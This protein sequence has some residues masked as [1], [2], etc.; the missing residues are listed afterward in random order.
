[1]PSPERT[2][3]LVL[4][5]WGIGECRSSSFV[6]LNYVALGDLSMA[7]SPGSRGLLTAL[8]VARRRTRSPAA[9][10]SKRLRIT[11]TRTP[12]RERLVDP[13]AEE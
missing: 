7:M 10:L 13:G 1:M 2:R 9:A 12:S 3:E 5:E 6:D 8:L 11:V 4:Y